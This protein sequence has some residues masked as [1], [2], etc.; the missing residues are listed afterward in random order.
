MFIP[1]TFLRRHLPSAGSRP[2]WHCAN[3]RLSGD[4]PY[5]PMIPCRARTLL[6]I[7]N[8]SPGFLPNGDVD[9]KG[10]AKEAS[11]PPINTRTIGE[12]LNDKGH[13]WPIMARVQRCDRL[14][15]DPSNPSPLV[16]SGSL[17]QHHNFGV[18]ATA[19]MGDAAQRAAHIKDATTS[20]AI[21]SE[22]QPCPRRPTPARRPPCVLETR[23]PR[24]HDQEDHRPSHIAPRSLWLTALI[25]TF[26]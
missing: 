12:A 25:V 21:D 16:K 17:L 5:H 15:H 2:A 7:S 19:I 9:T 11:I 6:Y 20:A 14:Q 18:Y 3:P 22:T 23:P 10:I 26:R 24:R 8:D 13:L 1:W 4:F